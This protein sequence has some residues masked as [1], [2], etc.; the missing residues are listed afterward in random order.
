MKP[1]IL[2]EHK[3][4]PGRLDIKYHTA[5]LAFYGLILSHQTLCVG[6][7]WGFVPNWGVKMSVFLSVILELG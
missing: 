2:G 5:V 6:Y 4:R 7:G 1:V 3:E